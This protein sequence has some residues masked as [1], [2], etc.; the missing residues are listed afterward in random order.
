MLTGPLD[1]PG[2]M[3]RIAGPHVED[4]KPFT[5]VTTVLEHV[6]LELEHRP[7]AM[8]RLPYFLDHDV[9]DAHEVD[10]VD[11]V[12]HAPQSLVI[13]AIHLRLKD[14]SQ[15]VRQCLRGGPRLLVHR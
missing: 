11:I 7:S 1:A 6:L 12:E 14:T 9:G 3:S 15:R 10:V 4:G 2:N 8:R 13:E 5:H